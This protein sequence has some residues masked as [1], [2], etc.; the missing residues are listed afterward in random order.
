MLFYII[1][2]LI[3]LAIIIWGGVTRWRFIGR[4]K[5]GFSKSSTLVITHNAGFFS[6]CLMRLEKIIE[7]I[8]KHGKPP[9]KVDSSQQFAYYKKKEHK[10]GDIT[11]DFF[12][13][14][15]EITI[16]NN[17]IQFTQHTYL[18]GTLH[19]RLDGNG[20]DTKYKLIN[21]NQVDPLIKKYFS[22]SK[23]INKIIKNI[24]QKYHID[25]NNCIGVF[26]RANDHA[27]DQQVA[28][29]DSFYNKIKEVNNK[30]EDM[31]II[32]QTDS[33]PFLDYI[34]EKNLK[35]IIIIEENI[36]FSGSVS[37]RV[38]ARGD[39][40]YEDISYLLATYLILSKCRYIIGGTSNGD[41][42]II[43]YRGNANN[44]FQYFSPWEYIGTNKDKSYDPNQKV[45]W[46]G[47]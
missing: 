12:N 6:C 19:T 28:P 27:G 35:N 8:N 24:K 47:S 18:D 44:I 10:G 38:T 29:F 37:A 4:K 25:C 31:K 39:K 3:I 14:N 42:W 26:F 15:K 23:R 33:K 11:S 17:K 40:N 5:E 32:I 41:L 46:F 36:Q 30:N 43:L 16:N 20:W 21:F 13:L 1:L 9:V 45:F 34:K 2:F 7:Y 22:P